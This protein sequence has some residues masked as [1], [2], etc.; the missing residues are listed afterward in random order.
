[1]AFSKSGYGTA[2]LPMIANLDSLTKAAKG[3]GFVR[4]KEE[5]QQA[6]EFH[7]AMELMAKSTKS[8]SYALG[9]ALMPLLREKTAKV[10]QITLGVRD[11]IKKN[12][13]LVVSVFKVAAGVLAAGAGLVVLGTVITGLGKAFG[14]LRTVITFPVTAF[15][16]LF[17][18]LGL[19]LSPT[20]LLATAVLGLGAY[21]LY[22]S[23]AI[24]KAVDW[25]KGGF[26][27]LKDDA[28]KSFDAIGKALASGRIDLAAKVL[29]TGLKVEFLRGQEQVRLAW[30]G[31]W[32]GLQLFVSETW[33]GLQRIVIEGWH[34]VSL[35]GI[36]AMDGLIKGAARIKQTFKDLG[37]MFDWGAK[38]L[39]NLTSGMT[40]Q[41]KANASQQLAVEANAKFTGTQKEKDA[42][43]AAENRA[44]DTA[45]ALEDSRYRQSVGNITKEDRA[46]QKGLHDA[47]VAELLA[48]GSA[49]D[50]AKADW[51]A[52]IAAVNAGAGAAGGTE[53]PAGMTDWVKFLADAGKMVA[54]MN[55]DLA[56]AGSKSSARGTFNAMASLSLQ[57]GGAADRTA[58]ATE[59]TARNTKTLLNKANTGGLTFA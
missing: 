10:I 25:L 56:G 24:G 18:I 45:M 53:P 55:A 13:D 48:S 34:L 32:L 36:N 11:W 5:V 57:G 59:E 3:M 1:M 8:L 15:K 47:Y 17:A 46:R 39:G 27:T 35:A 29:W 21:F 16:A 41:Q 52:A 33:T 19:L 23:G 37:V 42:Q 6:E 2:L 43:I 50:K 28:T 26:A 7:V 40:P 14:I 31:F 12:S 54:D 51:L 30:S 58:K 22:A 44:Y 38:E 9:G 20:A 4:S 49:V